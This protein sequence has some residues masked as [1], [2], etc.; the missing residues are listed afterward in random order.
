MSA[1]TLFFSSDW[2]ISFHIVFDKPFF[3][4]QMYYIDIAP[5]QILYEKLN[6]MN[7]NVSW[8][9]WTLWRWLLGSYKCGQVFWDT[10][11][12]EFYYSFPYQAW[13]SSCL[14]W[15]D[16]VCGPPFW[17]IIRRQFYNTAVS[18]WSFLKFCWL[19]Q[20]ST[21]LPYHTSVFFIFCK[22]S[23]FMH[24]QSMHIEDRRFVGL[25]RTTAAYTWKELS[26]SEWGGL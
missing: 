18:I 6:V 22:G 11:C 14:F 16:L 7:Q 17:S 25:A 23:T 5:V 8:L 3:P 24:K 1:N 26:V 10:D 13:F 12:N 4:F 19:F 20:H 15:Q 9:L 21:V 2:I